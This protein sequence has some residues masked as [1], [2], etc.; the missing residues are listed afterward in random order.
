MSRAYLSRT[1]SFDDDVTLIQLQP[2]KSIHGPLTCRNGT[3][4][5]LPLRR[6][7]MTVIQY[8]AELHRDEL[9]SQCPNIPIQ[10]KAFDVHV[11]DT[12]YRTTGGLVTPPRFDP[13][14]SILNNIKSPNTM[15][16][17]ES[18]ESEE[19]IDGVGD[20]FV[21]LSQER[22][23]ERQSRFELDGDLFWGGGC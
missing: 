20:S 21:L 2:H 19:D 13:D 18:V 5:E 6:E 22:D 15:F 11:C 17:A 12:Q 14:E 4:H 16:L 8:P 23:L 3:C 9:V 1:P 7:E 10:R